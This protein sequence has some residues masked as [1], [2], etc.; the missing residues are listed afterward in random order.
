MHFVKSKDSLDRDRRWI[1]L[2]CGS[3]SAALGAR[4]TADA[5]ISAVLHDLGLIVRKARLLFSHS[6]IGYVV[7]E[8]IPWIAIVCRKQ[9]GRVSL[10][11]RTS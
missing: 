9:C 11:G 2:T 4:Q 3:F 10:I 1:T 8:C 5:H 7:V 6:L